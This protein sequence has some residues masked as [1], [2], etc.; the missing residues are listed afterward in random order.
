MRTGELRFLPYKNV[1]KMKGK[2]MGLRLLFRYTQDS[3]RHW[4]ARCGGESENGHFKR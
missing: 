3:S 4:T 1:R 2:S